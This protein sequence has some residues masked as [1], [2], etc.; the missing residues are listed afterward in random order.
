MSSNDR[1]YKHNNM[2][3]WE[4]CMPNKPDFVHDDY[5]VSGHQ[6]L[7]HIPNAYASRSRGRGVSMGVQKGIWRV[8]G[9]GIQV[10]GTGVGK[11]DL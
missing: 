3:K 11:S 9:R 1:L 6:E 8:S 4:G 10:D 2:D 7:F 5:G